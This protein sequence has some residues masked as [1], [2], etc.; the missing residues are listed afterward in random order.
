MLAAAGSETLSELAGGTPALRRQAQ[1]TLSPSIVRRG[2]AQGTA[3]IVLPD[4]DRLLVP[5]LMSQ[6]GLR[7]NVL[8]LDSAGGLWWGV[9]YCGP[10]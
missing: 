2:D 3:Y 1:S 9:G 8:F 7:P 5:V 4:C 6:G 10:F